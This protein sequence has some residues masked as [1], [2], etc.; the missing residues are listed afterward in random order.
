MDKSIEKLIDEV[1]NLPHEIKAY[2]AEKLLENLDADTDADISPEWREEIE[3]RCAEI[4]SGLAVLKDSDEVFK[5]ALSR[6]K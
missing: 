1:L 5:S 3:R 4:D 2:L 6:L